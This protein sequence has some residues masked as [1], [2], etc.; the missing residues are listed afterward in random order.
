MEYVLAHATLSLARSW[1]ERCRCLTSTAIAP[2]DRRAV[3]ALYRRVFGTDAAEASRLRWEWQ[4]R[5]NPNNPGGEPEIWIAREGP[6]IVG[7]YATMPVKLAV[8][9][10]EINGLLGH[11][12]HG[13]ARTA[14][15]GARA[16]SCSARGT[17]TS[18]RRSGSGLSDASYRLFQKLRWPDVGPVPCLVKPLSRRAFRHPRW[19]VRDQPPHLGADAAARAASSRAARPLRAEVRLIQRFDDSFT[20]FW[21]GSGRSSTSPSGAT[22]RI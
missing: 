5:R 10:R 15:A 20:E 19:P 17:A 18:A 2:D 3:E 11:G 7:Q 21:D 8:K 4:Y 1:S 12:R 9:G 13:R 14:A 6:A 22:P 16:K